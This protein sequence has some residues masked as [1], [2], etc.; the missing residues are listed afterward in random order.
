MVIMERLDALTAPYVLHDNLTEVEARVRLNQLT[1][2][3]VA[4]GDTIKADFA[5]LVRFTSGREYSLQ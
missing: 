3:R 1:Q 2:E 5:N 4:A